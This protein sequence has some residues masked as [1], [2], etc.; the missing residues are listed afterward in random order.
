MRVVKFAPIGHVQA[1]DAGFLFVLASKCD[2]EGA[3]FVRV[4]NQTDYENLFEGEIRKTGVSAIFR[5]KVKRLTDLF[6]FRKRRNR[7]VT[8]EETP[9]PDTDDADDQQE[10]GE[11][12]LRE[13]ATD[14]PNEPTKKDEE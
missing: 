9:L 14:T 6:D 4:Y 1:P 3:R 11:D 13:D 12:K 2:A 7:T 5:R 8:E 10:D